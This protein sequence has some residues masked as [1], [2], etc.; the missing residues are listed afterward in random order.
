MAEQVVVIGGSIAGLGAGLGLARR[1]HSVTIIERDPEPSTTDPEEAFRSWERRGVPQSR[2]PHGFLARARNLLTTYAPDVVDRMLAAGVEDWNVI[3][4]VPPEL[5]EPGDELFAGLLA[6]RIPFELALRQAAQAEPRLELR[7]GTAVTGLLFADSANTAAPTVTGVRLE[8]GTELAADVVLDAGGRR[9]PVPGWLAERGVE[10]PQDVQDC[11]MHYFGKYYRLRDGVDVDARQIVGVNGDLG[12]AIYGGFAGDDRTLAWFIGTPRWEDDFRVLRHNAAWDALAGDITRM[13]PWVDG[14][15]TEPITDV[16]FMTGHQN[17]L[18]RYVDNGRPLVSGLLPIGDALCTTNPAFGWGSS[19]ALTYAFAAVD[20][21]ENHPD[22]VARA[23]AY[24]DAVIDEAEAAYTTSAAQDRIRTY[25]WKGEE[26]PD[27]DK[28]EAVR[29]D[30]LQ[31]GL[32]PAMRRD[33]VVLRAMLRRMHLIDHPNA[34]FENDA[35]V[36]IGREIAEWRQA[37][38]ADRRLGP[39]RDEA[40][41]LLAS[42]RAG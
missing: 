9:S 10:I 18:R 42:V 33:F 26:I 31:N 2:Q 24:H 5:Q 21:I 36:Q 20:A 29:Q 11:E 35:V 23:V 34:I 1:G 6:R 3:E 4:L 22:P 28:E 39:T 17:T 7:S 41:Q 16:Q 37:N 14:T 30:L 15:T 12:Y 8:D 38:L 25:R 40:L 19:L 13:A 32:T 27:H